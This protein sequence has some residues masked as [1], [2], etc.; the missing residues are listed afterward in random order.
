MRRCA[1]Y[2]WGR[3]ESG[4]SFFCSS[5]GAVTSRFRLITSEITLEISQRLWHGN[6]VTLRIVNANLAKLFKYRLVLDKLGDRLMPHNMTDFI[7]RLNRSKVD[8]VFEYI[9]YKNTVYFEY[10]D[11]QVFQI[12]V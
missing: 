8:L 3:G 1:R 10:V 11:G 7:N 4:Q 6:A 9:L 12:G 2:P 5:F